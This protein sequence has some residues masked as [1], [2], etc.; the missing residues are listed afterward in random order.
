[1]T[2]FALEFTP[3]LFNNE[4]N[5]VRDEIQTEGAQPEAVLCPAI[6]QPVATWTGTPDK[7]TR[8]GCS[9]IVEPRH[10]LWI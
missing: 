1:M 3:V 5:D 9:A 2:T 8:V 7:A 4:D 6:P 10:S